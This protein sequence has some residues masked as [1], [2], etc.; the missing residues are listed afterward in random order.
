MTNR[1]FSRFHALV[2][3]GALAGVDP[4]LA[5][6]GTTGGTL[7]IAGG[8]LQADNAA[9]WQAFLDAKRAVGPIVIVPSASGSPDQSA[10]SARAALQS[11]G[12]VAEDVIVAPL[13]LVDDPSTPAVDEATWA[14][15]IDDPELAA[16]LRG[17]A[18][19]WFT[20]GDQARTTGLLLHEDGTPTPALTAIRQ[21]QARGASVGGTSA[22]AAIMSR[23]MILQGDALTALTGSKAGER[24]EVGIGLGFFQDGLVDQHFGQRARLGR[25]AAALLRVPEPD[26]RI[27]YGIDENTALVVS[28][29]GSARVLGAGYVAVID[30][31]NAKLDERGDARLALT[32]LVLHLLAPGDR[33][34]LSSLAIEPAA[35]RSPTIGAEYYDRRLL[36]GSG[37]ALAG[38]T[39][40]DV[41]GI[42]LLD[43]K[44]TTTIERISFGD[45][46]LGVVYRFSQTAAATGAWGR[47]PAGVAHYSIAGVAFDLLPV[48]VAVQPLPPVDPPSAR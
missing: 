22:G 40:P 8:A 31:R 21:A 41:L 4:A 46:G 45:D 38:Q 29:A 32:G 7:T 25:L 30:A 2:L 47:N 24:L 42:G 28:D 17:A 43:D 39:L 26:A 23:Q 34:D 3:A 27:G 44:A 20:G 33:I 1:K 10:A 16:V 9:V 6:T 5:E 11:Q 15:N 48:D 36:T 18:A 14:E 13:A 12:A 19:I 35:W 37:M